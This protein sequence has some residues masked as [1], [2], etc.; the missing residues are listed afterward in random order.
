MVRTAERPTDILV[1]RMSGAMT[2][3]QSVHPTADMTDIVYLGKFLGDWRR[4]VGIQ[5]MDGHIKVERGNMSAQVVYAYEGMS[6]AVPRLVFRARSQELSPQL[7]GKGNHRRLLKRLD[8]DGP[9]YR[10]GLKTYHPIVSV[11]FIRR[12]NRLSKGGFDSSFPRDDARIKME[13]H[14]EYGQ[15]LSVVTRGHVG[16]ENSVIP[17]R[18]P[19]V[20]FQPAIP[21]EFAMMYAEVFRLVQES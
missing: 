10:S 13:L 21:E 16:I 8:D 19:G 12:G 1:N 4:D 14:H 3:Y 15:D 17:D 9:E 5:K 18:F 6:V 7:F 11:S 20:D 2:R